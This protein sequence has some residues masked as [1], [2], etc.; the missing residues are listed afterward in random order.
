MMG[1]L[2]HPHVVRLYGCCIDAERT[3]WI[4]MEHR[5]DHRSR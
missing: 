1:K 2:S 4:V 5:E 3:L